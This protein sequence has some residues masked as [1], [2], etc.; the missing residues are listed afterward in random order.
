MNDYFDH[1][2]RELRA[3]VR[4]RAHLPWH[5]RWRPRR[6]RALVVVLAGLVLSGTAVAAQQITAHSG[7]FLT[8]SSPNARALG[9]GEALVM[10]APDAVAV[11]VRETSD[12]PFAPG[13]RFWRAKD[14][15]FQLS[16]S[17][18]SPPVGRAFMTVG[19]LR[20]AVADAAA[21]SWT[22]DWLLAISQH[23]TVAARRAQSELAASPARS[24]NGGTTE[25]T[26]LALLEI[27]VSHRDANLVRALIDTGRAGNCTALGPF[28]PTQLTPKQAQSRLHHAAAEG[29]KILGRDPLARRLG[30]PETE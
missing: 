13:Y 17:P 29:A 12:I 16:L 2:E 21:C 6:S 15:A 18:G 23:D 4:N 3:G 27:A 22:N 24:D 14:V 10:G 5:A 26:R 1:V 19:A 25:R 11:G 9:T 8:R 20:R 7:I 30:I 28:P